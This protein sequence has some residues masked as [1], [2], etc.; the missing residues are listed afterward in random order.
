M[1]G[2]QLDE[3]VTFRRRE[4]RVERIGWLLVTAVFVVALVGGFGY[5][6][7]SSVEVM[8]GDA[9]VQ[10]TRIVHRENDD[11]LRVNGPGT[12]IRLTGDWVQA[13]DIEQVVPEPE[14]MA[15]DADSMTMEFAKAGLHVNISYRAQQLGPLTGAVHLEGQSF[16]LQQVVLP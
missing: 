4:W 12:T 8:A 11:D 10:Y 7:V 15:A 1:A 9:D 3:N 16:E 13:V 6:P 2:L 5:G 14:S